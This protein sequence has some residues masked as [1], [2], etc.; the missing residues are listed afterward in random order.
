MRNMERSQ[1]INKCVNILMLFATFV[2]GIMI[3]FPA[4]KVKADTINWPITTYSGQY[5]EEL[6]EPY[7]YSPGSIYFY[8]KK[9]VLYVEKDKTLTL[10]FSNTYGN[11]PV[12]Y[13]KSDTYAYPIGS[14]YGYGDGWQICSF[15]EAF[16]TVEDG[17][18]MTFSYEGKDTTSTYVYTR[19]IGYSDSGD[20]LLSLSGSRI[21]ILTIN[22]TDSNNSSSVEDK[23]SKLYGKTF[24]FSGSKYS[25]ISDDKVSLIAIPKNSSGVL[26]LKDT[27]TYK[28][29]KYKVAT[30]GAKAFKVKN[31]V[32]S[33]VFGKNIV[34]IEPSAFAK[35]NN[36]RAVTFGKSLEIIGSKAFFKCGNLHNI[37]VKSPMLK[38]VGTKAFYKIDRTAH[39]SFSSLKAANK[40]EV[41]KLFKQKSIGYVKT[42]SL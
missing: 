35:L 42:W 18:T 28:G 8:D 20:E 36:L 40:K 41:K 33:V 30:I 38:S 10:T 12:Y 37:Y 31:S 32:T 3:L 17:N 27:V 22:W 9:D 11:Y 23:T 29:K 7:P 21:I 16:N 4:M 19:A 2:I 14:G 5:K 34:E 1:K 26:R 39:F 15:D 24:K 25:I 6:G 13:F